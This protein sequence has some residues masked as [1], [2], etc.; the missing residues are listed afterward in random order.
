[1]Q[2]NLSG[3]SDYDEPTTPVASNVVAAINKRPSREHGHRAR[4][5]VPWYWTL[6]AW[7]VGVPVGFAI[8]ALPIYW[9]RLVTRNDLL[10]VFVGTGISRY[11]RLAIATA[12]W[13]LAIAVTVTLITSFAP[14]RRISS[15]KNDTGS[16]AA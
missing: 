2:R 1:M 12:L 4:R 8:T 9:S 5:R 14:R 3:N 15:R 11:L 6:G 7:V 13:A 16:R 10:N